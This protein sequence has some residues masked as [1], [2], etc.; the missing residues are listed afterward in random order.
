MYYYKN[1]EAKKEFIRRNAADIAADLQHLV[2]LQDIPANGDGIEA[3]RFYNVVEQLSEI[4]KKITCLAAAYETETGDALNS[5]DYQI[6][7]TLV[8]YHDLIEERN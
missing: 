7:N 5:K 4:K 2:E 6:I 3:I 8:M 1:D